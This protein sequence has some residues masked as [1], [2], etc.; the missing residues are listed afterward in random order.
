MCGIAGAFN[1][2]GPPSRDLL[3]A[4]AVA[5][6]HRGPD[7]EGIESGSHWGLV[8]RRLAIIGVSDGHQPIANEDGSVRVVF[9]GEIYNHHA[10]RATLEANGHR[11]S[12][13]SDTEVLVHLY[14]EHGAGLTTH[15]EGMFA[16]AVYDTRG[17]ERLLLARDR[18]GQKPLFYH[19]GDDGGLV[20]ASELAALLLSPRVPR[21]ID[22]V[23]LSEYLSLGYV[24]APA[25]IFRGVK[26][27]PPAHTVMF[28]RNPGSSQSPVPLRYWCPSYH[29]DRAMTFADASHRARELIDSA[30]KKRLES[31][32]PLGAFLSGGVDSTVVVGAMQGMLPD[33]VKTFCIGFDSGAY[34]ERSY[35]QIAAARFRTEHRVKVAEPRDTSLLRRL[36]RHYG[37]PFADSSML[38]TALLSEFAAQHVTVALSGDGGDEV[39]GGYLRYQV[40]ALQRYIATVPLGLRRPV[41]DLILAALPRALER[42]STLYT[43]RRLLRVWRS[44]AAEGY[45]TFQEA[46]SE[47]TRGELVH[48]REKGTDGAPAEAFPSWA[49]LLTR[50]TAHDFV[51]QFQELDLHTYLPSDILYKVDIATMAYSLEV[52]SPFLDHELIEFAAAVPRK[53]KVTLTG[54]KRLLKA[55]AGDL[56]PEQIRGRNKRGFGVPISA[57][58][59]H[60][61]RAD[62]E[63]L[64]AEEQAAFSGLSHETIGRLVR[65]HLAGSHDHGYGLWALLCLKLW[66]DEMVST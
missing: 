35:A 11:F 37:E 39:F 59:R 1:L 55:A 47:H 9:N 53:F 40:M 8:S 10:L 44:R 26:K 52:R 16:F 51:E 14:E 38:P 2:P 25:T 54:R 61:L 12:S 41:C 66:Y 21:A 5:L 63:A 29:P 22:G 19:E 62:A 13:A 50:G 18:L 30:V 48:S 24:P 3:S 42:H 23:A 65:E 45:R 58:L 36:V 31:E 33:P 64:A 32:V 34:D 43:A 15:L 28:E 6:A 56:L 27:L 60:E 17:G 20:F 46:F 7:D 4:M 49:E 57:W